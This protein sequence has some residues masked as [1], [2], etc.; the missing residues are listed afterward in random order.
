[1]ADRNGFNLQDVSPVVLPS[2]GFRQRALHLPYATSAHFVGC[3][4]LSCAMDWTVVSREAGGTPPMTITVRIIVLILAIPTTL[5]CGLR[6]C[7]IALY[8]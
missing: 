7:L 8:C 6:V 2:S 3:G 5:V 1:M 4:T